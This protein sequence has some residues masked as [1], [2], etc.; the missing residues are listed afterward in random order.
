M[1]QK[2]TT[3]EFLIKLS[4]FILIGGVL[5]FAFLVWRFKLFQKIDSISIG[6]WGIVAILFLAIFFMVMLKQIRKG[7]KYSML[8]QI[9]DLTCN[10]LIP[11]LTVIL[12]L[13]FAKNSYDGLMSFLIVVFVCEIPAGILNPI[14]RWTY[15]NAKNEGV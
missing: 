1:Q 15:E 13:N 5:P 2:M 14:P 9:L 7:M 6:G 4:L 11:I 3:K 12:I 8:K 10:I